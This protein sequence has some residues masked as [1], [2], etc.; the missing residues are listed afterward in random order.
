MREVTE[1]MEKF[2]LGIAAQ[3]IYDFIYDDLC[4]WYIEMVKPRLYG[5][6]AESKKA[7]MWTLNSVLVDAL[8]LLHPYMPFITEEIFCTLK[9]EQGSLESNESIMISSWPE[10]SADRAFESEEEAV[11]LIKEAVKGIR[12]VRTE[13]N[14]PMS[15][16]AAVFVVSDSDKVRRIFENSRVFFASLGGASS[17]TIQADKAGIGEDAVSTLI[18]GATIYIPFA[19]LVDIAKE[20][21][22]LEK[23]KARLE[24]E[25]KRVNGMLANPN[26]VNKAPEAK[27]AEEKA[28]LAKYTD[29]FKQVEERLASL[30]K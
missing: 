18:H 6:A 25:L 10:Y 16:K 27:L 13:M 24:G 5:D 4:D 9:E 23:E 3:K 7:A 22:R 26:F 30:K 19:E 12:N 20:I 21:E 14:V 29:M 1:A 11:E 17:V 8:K 28:K 15:R 2:E